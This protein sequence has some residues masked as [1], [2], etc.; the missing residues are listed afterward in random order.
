MERAQRAEALAES[1]KKNDAGSGSYLENKKLA[2]DVKSPPLP[3]ACNM[4]ECEQTRQ[5]ISV[6]SPVSDSKKD[7]VSVRISII[8]A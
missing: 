6:C 2:A 8:N 4:R 1:F 5:N 7:I 3:L